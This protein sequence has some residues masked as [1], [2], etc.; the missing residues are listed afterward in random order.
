MT[1]RKFAKVI[2]EEFNDKQKDM[3]LTVYDS[4]EDEYYLVTDVTEDV[5]SGVLD[6]KHPIL[7]IK[8]D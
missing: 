7:V 1:Y 5:D 8:E 2:M 6:D 4:D 3:D